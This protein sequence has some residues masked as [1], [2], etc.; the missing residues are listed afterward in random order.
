MLDCS[1][2]LYYKYLATSHDDDMLLPGGKQ[3]AR[4]GGPLVW[5]NSG[6]VMCFFFTIESPLTALS[7]WEKLQLYKI[8]L[9]YPEGIRQPKVS[10][11]P[12]CAL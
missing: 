12:M 6:V 3:D 4:L 1:L 7:L 2:V 11:D 5:S 8:L 9:V 10:E